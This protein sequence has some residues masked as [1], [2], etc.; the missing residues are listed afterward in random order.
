MMNIGQYLKEIRIQL[1]LNLDDVER[2]TDGIV[3]VACLNQIETGAIQSPSPHLLY[4]LSSAYGEDYGEF[5]I[6]ARY[7]RVKGG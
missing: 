3:T 7:A 5:M 1:K 2:K 6:K 4:Y